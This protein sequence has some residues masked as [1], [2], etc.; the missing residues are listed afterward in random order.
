M[1]H[2]VLLNDLTFKLFGQVP[3]VRFSISTLAIMRALRFV[4]AAAQAQ[5]VM[6]RVL[7]LNSRPLASNLRVC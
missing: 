7:M 1:Q 3:P 5:I 4:R 2:H 6:L